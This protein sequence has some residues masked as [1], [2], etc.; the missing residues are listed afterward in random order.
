MTDCYERKLTADDVAVG[1]TAPEINV[2]DVQRKDFVK[3]A[4]ASGDFNPIHYDEPYAKEA[5]NDSVFGQ[6]MLT[7]GY[8]SHMIAD[9]FGLE[10]VTR[11]KVRFRA[12]LFPGD[13]LTVSGEITDVGRHDDGAT[14]IAEFAVTNQDDEQLITG[15]ATADLPKV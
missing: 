1:D 14:V 15:E 6:G 3:Y 10:N 9:W 5:G 8:A 11:F 7:A 12:R 4:G 2:E 13:C